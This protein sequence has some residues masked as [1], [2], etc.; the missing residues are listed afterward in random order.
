M[1]LR[2]SYSL[3]L[4]GLGMAALVIAPYQEAQ[5]LNSSE[6]SKIA[7]SITIRIEGQNPGSGVIIERQG[8]TYTVLTAAHVV[9][10]PDEYELILPDNQRVALDYSTVQKLSGVDLALVK[11]SSKNNYPVAKLG[12]STQASSGTVSYVAGFPLPSSAI[13]DPVF[14]FSE[15]KISA[16]AN[17][18]LADGYA[19]IYSNDTL[20]G[21]SGGAVLN[22]AGVLIGIHGR[23]D[24]QDLVQRTETI[25]VKTGFNLGIPINTFTRLTEPVNFGLDSPVSPAPAAN[26]TPDDL[27]LSAYEKSEAG[28]NLGAIVDLD[29][30]IR[31]APNSVE[32]Y[33]SR[34]LARDKIGRYEEAIADYGKALQ[35]DPNQARIYNNRG[36]ARAR[37][38]DYSGAIA[39][40]N[41]VLQLDPNHQFAH[42]NRGSA[43]VSLEDYK[44]ALE[45]YTVAIERN[46]INV[47]SYFNRGKL[48]ANAAD[49]SGAIKDFDKAIQLE[50][51]DMRF[52]YFRGS[53]RDELGNYDGAINDFQKAV[54]INHNFGSAYAKLGLLEGKLGKARSAVW[55]LERAAQIFQRQG[56][57]DLMREMLRLIQVFKKGI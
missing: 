24:K 4:I 32:A 29:H 54:Q 20:P 17:R 14:I 10:T 30:A 1:M 31:L 51:R 46:P 19:L 23:A 42:H 43:R 33:V 18:P 5:A 48:R 56:Q 34:G 40:F 41:K 25:A 57:G 22:Q 6:V 8:E 47:S 26:I 27:I 15:G 21:M 55:H 28:Q 2:S 50:P 16:N 52:Y 11:F 44:G 12:D 38:E 37:L 7:K 9:E 3:P 36:T 49:H 45:D 13:S 53:S 39:D 35:L